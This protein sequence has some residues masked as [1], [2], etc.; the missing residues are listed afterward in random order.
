MKLQFMTGEG[1]NYLIGEDGDTRIY[2]EIALPAGEFS[3][4]F[5]YMVLKAAVLKAVDAAGVV[6]GLS[7]WYDGQESFLESDANAGG[8]VY[9]EIE[10]NSG[11]YEMIY[12]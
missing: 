10:N 6:G 8:S 4:D 9:V 1:V 7:F 5:G 2:A 3:D 12:E 11:F